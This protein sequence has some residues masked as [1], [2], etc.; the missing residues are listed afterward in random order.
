MLNETQ[1]DFLAREWEFSH[2]KVISLMGDYRDVFG[3]CLGIEREEE[4]LFESNDIRHNP[5]RLKM[6]REIMHVA[7]LVWHGH[8]R[9]SS[10]FQS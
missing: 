2:E 3:G 5:D 1:I 9:C 10:N 8:P 6:A 7:E 4:K